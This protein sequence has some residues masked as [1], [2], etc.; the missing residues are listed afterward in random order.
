MDKLLNSSF[1]LHLEK[2][3]ELAKRYKTIDI[4]DGNIKYESEGKQYNITSD[5]IEIGVKEIT[6]SWLDRIYKVTRRQTKTKYYDSSYCFKG[7]K[8]TLTIKFNQ[9]I[10]SLCGHVNDERIQ[11]I[12]DKYSSEVFAFVDKNI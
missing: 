2:G 11:K 10:L 4:L 7:M 1:Y 8:D 5:E 12:F 9:I 3:P 6:S